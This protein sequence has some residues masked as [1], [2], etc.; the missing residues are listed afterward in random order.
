MA[1]TIV[2]PVKTRDLQN[3]HIDSTAWDRFRFRDN[4]IIIGTYAKSGTTWMQQIVSQLIFERA[5]G[6]DIPKLSPWIDFR[7]VPD[8]VRQALEQ[9]THRRFLKTHLP[10]DALVFSHRAKYIYIGRDGRDAARSFFNHY[11]N[12]SE[13]RRA[14]MIGPG[15]VGP[16]LPPCP[17]TALEFYRTWV[18]ENGKPLWPYWDS[19]R[20]WWAIRHLPNVKFIHFNLLK[21]D[22]AGSI[23]AVAAFLD[24]RLSPQSLALNREPLHLRLPEAPRNTC[25]AEWWRPLQGR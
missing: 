22:L 11:S 19:I 24:F 15:L 10:V 5:E 18:A 2:W 9:Q 14:A 23:A 12:L 6:I 3:H 1:E 20:S 8:H 4:D 25:C 7:L 21:A 13:E 17:P 16:P